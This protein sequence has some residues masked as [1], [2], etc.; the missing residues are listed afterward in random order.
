[1][2]MNNS[3]MDEPLYSFIFTAAAPHISQTGMLAKFA[4]NQNRVNKMEK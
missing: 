3:R 1:M 2:R 4:A